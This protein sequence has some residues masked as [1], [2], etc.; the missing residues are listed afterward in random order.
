I[1]NSL[2]EAA[3]SRLPEPAAFIFSLSSQVQEDSQKVLRAAIS[4]SRL[5]T[6]DAP[7]L[8]WIT[9]GEAC[10]WASDAVRDTIILKIGTVGFAHAFDQ[11]FPSAPDTWRAGGWGLLSG[12]DGGAY[13]IGRQVLYRLF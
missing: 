2:A 10:W 7:R 12:D 1:C 9:R 4:H 13:F 11:S 5:R 8:S 6:R 3:Q